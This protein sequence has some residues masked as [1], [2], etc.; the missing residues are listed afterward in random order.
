MNLPNLPK[1]NKK[2]EAKFSIAF[3]KWLEENPRH[4]CT[5]EMKD[6]R[7]KGSL[8]FSEVK[9][10]QINWARA[11]KS[12]DGVLMRIEPIIEGMPDYAYY[13]NAPAYIV[14]KYP[15]MFCLIDVD[16][17]V[18]ERDRSKKAS[19]SASRADDISTLTVKL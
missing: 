3:R 4:S 10:K 19:L 12:D 13:R 6:T 15:K 14:I 1:V 5:F 17:F 2:H 18:L 8:P 11:V 7:G 9:G 16:T